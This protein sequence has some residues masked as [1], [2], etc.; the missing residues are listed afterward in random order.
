VRQLGVMLNTCLLICYNPRD[1]LSDLLTKTG[2][3]VHKVSPR[4]QKAVGSGY[5]RLVEIWPDSKNDFL[6]K[7]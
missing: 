5:M 7:R 4:L 2:A 6:I 3:V 1:S